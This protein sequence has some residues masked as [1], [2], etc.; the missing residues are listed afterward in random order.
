MSSGPH[1][2]ARCG[3]F[4]VFAS[5]LACS[6]SSDGG[7]VTPG[8]DNDAGADAGADATPAFDGAVITELPS[9]A[10]GASLGKG[11]VTSADIAAAD[12]GTVTSYDGRLSVVLAAGALSAD[13]TVTITTIMSSAPGGLGPAY[14]LDSGGVSFTVATIS[15]NFGPMDLEGTAPDAIELASQG[16]DGTWTIAGG[17]TVTPTTD[18]SGDPIGGTISAQVTHFSPWAMLWGWQ[19]QPLEA[20]VATSDHLQLVVTVC[21]KGQD[22]SS[23]QVTLLPVC[24]PDPDPVEMTPYV[25][26]EAGGDSTVGTV[27]VDPASAQAVDSISYTAPAAVPSPATVA[28]SATMKPAYVKTGIQLV[29]HVTVQSQP[30]GTIRVVAFNGNYSA[31]LDRGQGDIQYDHGTISTFLKLHFQLTGPSYVDRVTWG[32]DKSANLEVKGFLYWQ[33][34]LTYADPSAGDIRSTLACQPQT[35]S[36]PWTDPDVQ[37]NS[38]VTLTYRPESKD[39][40]LHFF[41]GPLRNCHESLVDFPDDP[42]SREV[43]HDDDDGSWLGPDLSMILTPGADPNRLEGTSVL[44]LNVG[45]GTPDAPVGVSVEADVD[46][47]GTFANALQ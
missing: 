18:G 2:F 37:L 14:L 9:D 36:L 20:D 4:F 10:K 11:F 45:E 41:G 28:V 29:S 25:N 26:G 42:D 8:G 12:G 3:L 43:D 16:D 1:A 31:T 17:A 6:S 33:D 5:M 27:V 23:G 22:T 30:H 24:L 34:D 19:L 47:Q 44:T 15:G 46:L 13:A 32:L 21:Q 38:G 39:F 40:L 35:L 7:G